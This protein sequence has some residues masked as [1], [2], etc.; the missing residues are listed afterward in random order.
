MFGSRARYLD[1]VRAGV[2]APSPWL[3]MRGAVL[4]SDRF[5]AALDARLWPAAPA[6]EFPRRER[7]VARQCLSERLPIA[8]TID[9]GV[10]NALIQEVARRP[11]YTLAEIGRHLGLH[12]STI[13]RI[14][15][16][17]RRSPD[18]KR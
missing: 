8:G 7:L 11:D 17:G 4:G 14:V 10:R 16:Q 12:Y 6:S 15:A 1:F 9:R 3:G 2:G 13:S 5:V 18:V